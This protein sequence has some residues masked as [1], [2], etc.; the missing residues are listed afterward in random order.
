MLCILWGFESSKEKGRSGGGSDFP[1]LASSGL[2]G[3][4]HLLGGQDKKVVFCMERSS[5]QEW[6]KVQVIS[7]GRHAK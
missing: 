6:K 1:P 3:N 5:I 4:Q 7:G 2:K